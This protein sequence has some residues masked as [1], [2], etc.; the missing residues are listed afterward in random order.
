MQ[1]SPVSSYAE[2]CGIVVSASEHGVR[3]DCVVPYFGI[4]DSITKILLDE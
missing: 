4:F 1:T 3:L 2:V